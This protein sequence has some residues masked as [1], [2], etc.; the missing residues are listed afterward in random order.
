VPSPLPSASRLPVVA[1]SLRL[2]CQGAGFDT[3]CSDSDKLLRTVRIE[4][5]VFCLTAVR[6]WCDSGG[7]ERPEWILLWRGP[8]P[9]G[10]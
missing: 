1:K 4:R 9:I 2:L 10:S 7:R 8:R 3:A 6:P 5:G